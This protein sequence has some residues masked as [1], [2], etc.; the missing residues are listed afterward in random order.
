MKEEIAANA[1]DTLTPDDNAVIEGEE[2][3][4][5]E[6]TATSDTPALGEQS[7]PIEIDER[8]KALNKLAFEKREEK[9][10]ADTAEKRVRELESQPKASQPIDKPVM[11]KESDFDYETDKFN[12]ALSDYTV[13]LTK[14][15]TQEALKNHALETTQSQESQR[16]DTIYTE[17]DKK[18]AGSGINNFYEVTSNLP[19][20]DPLV[21][22][23]MM[24]S[25]NAPKLVHYLSEHLD[26]AD[27]IASSSP[28]VAA[29]KIGEISIRLDKT[30]STN[31]ISNAPDPIDP[32]NQSGAAT[33]EKDDPSL[34]GVTFT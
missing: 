26:V 17:F 15:T 27:M 30:K 16:L 7:Q 4:A 21:R 5:T 29:M 25:E 10:R 14:Y 32:I 11:P 6:D 1:E 24:Q 18:V 20:F 33:G 12:Q 3:T 2:S 22:E 23:A 19:A 31:T 28:L 8:Q 13:N 9:R 34:D